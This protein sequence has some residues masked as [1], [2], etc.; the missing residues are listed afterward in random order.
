MKQWPPFDAN[1]DLPHG[2]HQASL[3]QVMAHFDDGSAQRRLVAERLRRI[4][5]LAMQTNAVRRFIIFGSFVTD[6]VAPNDADV[7]LVMENHFD[8]EAVVGE[9]K[10]VFD[11]MAA[12]NLLGASIFWIPLA[13]CLD[14]EEES[15]LY[16][17]I[18]RDKTHRGIVEVTQYDQE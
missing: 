4:Y 17:T 9:A 16:W 1:G 2:L 7:F 8:I 15:V 11:H 18:K 14:G 13:A 12:H 10:H 6:K 5:H 3:Q